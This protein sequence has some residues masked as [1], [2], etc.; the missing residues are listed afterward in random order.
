MEQSEP[1]HAGNIGGRSVWYCWTAP[2]NTVVT[3]DTVG[4]SIDTVLAVYT[5]TDLASLTE[6]ASDDDSGSNQTS[7]LVFDATRGTTYHIAVD[8]F[9][10]SAPGNFTLR[11]ASASPPPPPPP[12]PNDAFGSCAPLTGLAGQIT[13]S[14]IGATSEQSEPAHAGNTGG[15]SVWY[16]WT[17]PT[18]TVV[19]LDTVGSSIDTVLAVYT[20]TDLASLTEMASD[21]DS[22][23]N[24]T[25][26][27]VFDATSGTIYRIAVD[28]FAGTAPGNFA[29]RWASASPPPPPNDI[30]LTV[31]RQTS[32]NIEVKLHAP[33]GVYFLQTSTNFSGWR[34]LST[35]IMGDTPFGFTDT[36]RTDRTRFY[37][38][39]RQP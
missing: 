1:A 26:R 16:C 32:G 6:I 38:A 33:R 4:S 18:N 22:G 25:S 10:D 35:M 28:N 5:G 19:T 13:G 8:N 34:T 15:R 36:N 12:P 14:N 31:R 17:A 24:Q 21:N 3:L 23:S 7:R 27:V 11:W 39:M 37:R 29:L 2:T 20:G 9:A 30:W